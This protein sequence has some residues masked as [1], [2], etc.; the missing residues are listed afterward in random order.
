MLQRLLQQFAPDRYAV[1]TDRHSAFA[2]S[3]GDGWLPVAHYFRGSRGP[4]FPFADSA[5]AAR[6]VAPNSRG[7]TGGLITGAI[8]RMSGL[9]ATAGLRDLTL[10]AVRTIETENS[11][12]VLATSSDPIFMIAAAK[13]A[14]LTDRQLYVHLFDLFAGNRYPLPK[15]LLASRSEADVL[16]DARRVFVPN[17][18]MASHYRDRLGIRPIVIPNGTVIPGRPVERSVST[19]PTILYTGAIYWAQLDSLRNL[20]IALRHLP[21]VRFEVRTNASSYHVM[22]AGLSKEHLS[23]GFAS[24][25]LSRRAQH[26]ADILFLPLAF[27]TS[28]PAVIRTALP[29]KTAEYLVSGTPI[30]VHAP[31]DA[32]ITRYARAAKWG[33]VVDT[34]DPKGL[35]IAV[36]KLLGDSELRAA[37]VAA[38]YQEAVR[39]HDLEKIAP[40]YARHFS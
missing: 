23:A 24:Q 20:A 16:R 7:V 5:P 31:P 25:E 18:A 34:P 4:T 8:N 1:F 27:R 32:Y 36:Q 6:A 9:N 22:R 10:S 26:K 39:G 37:L 29:A 19:A 15:R 12:I 38:A 30:L 14:R 40:E 33:Y 21:G 35:A 28:A 2:G 11:E 17:E 3:S 13:A